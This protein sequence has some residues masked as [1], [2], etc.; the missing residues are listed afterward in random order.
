[1]FGLSSIGAPTKTLKIALLTSTQEANRE[2]SLFLY[3]YHDLSIGKNDNIERKTK[4]SKKSKKKK[5]KKER[6]KERKKEP[7]LVDFKFRLI[8]TCVSNM[9]D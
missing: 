7:R 5:K 6:K 4:Q 3:Q 2:R 8:L 9:A 1:M